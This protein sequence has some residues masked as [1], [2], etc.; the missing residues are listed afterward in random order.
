MKCPYCK[1]EDV[2][3]V[4]TRK[5]DTC[6]IRVRFCEGCR[7]SFQTEELIQLHTPIRFTH[8]TATNP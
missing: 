3:V 1:S 2:K 6:I 8:V 4:D 7:T 5:Y